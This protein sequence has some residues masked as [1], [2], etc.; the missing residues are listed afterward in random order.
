MAQVDT[1]TPLTAHGHFPDVV[2][3]AF[4]DKKHMDDFLRGN[5]R[6][7]SLSLYRELEDDT[8]RDN[9]EGIS[10]VSHDGL[11]HHG[12]MPGTWV[13]VLCCSVSLDAI[14]KSGFGSYIVQ[15]RNPRAL[16]EEL[17]K[18]LVLRPEMFYEGV[19]GVLVKYSKGHKATAMPT[20][21]DLIRLSYSQKPHRFLGDEEFRFV[22]IRK[23]IG[24]RAPEKHL[25]FALGA[26]LCYSEPARCQHGQAAACMIG[27]K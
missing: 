13:Y 22:V 6:F 23:T 19:E 26:T 5:I 20:P 18:K 11:D 12:A 17:T 14:C 1:A 24:I 15:I 4:A 21:F 7:G 27:D 8:R 2:Y 9:L 16:A 10:H 25:T 3:R